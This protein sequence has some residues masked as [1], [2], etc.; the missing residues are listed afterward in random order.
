[1]GHDMG[2]ASREKWERKV[3]SAIQSAVQ[4]A[5]Q[6]KGGGSPWYETNLLWVPLTTAFAIILFVVAAM[7]KGDFRL[8]LL[9]A[10]GLLVHPFWILTSNIGIRRAYLQRAV[11]VL[12][13]LLSASGTYGFYNYLEEEPIAV[14]PTEIKLT[15]LFH[16]A[17]G[18]KGVVEFSV[19]NRGDDPYYEI[20]AK[21]LVTSD[22]L[23]SETI[24][25]D[26]PTVEERIGTGSDP[27]G[28]ALASG[29]LRGRDKD[30]HS[31]FLCVIDQLSPK[32][33]F[34]IQLTTAQTNPSDMPE[35][36]IGT[37]SIQIVKFSNSPGRRFVNFPGKERGA[38]SEH[39]IP[40]QFTST[41]MIHFC[42]DIGEPFKS[43]SPITCTPHSKYKIE[44]PSAV[45][46]KRTSKGT[47]TVSPLN[48]S[49]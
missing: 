7:M 25:L 49:L 16:P 13:L 19:Y 29:C 44:K 10:F 34:K 37:T 15:D 14:S 3:Q 20:W 41:T 48:A 4:T 24:D 43:L 5:S 46:F 1:M 21:I 47:S 2:R 6:N 28:V 32:D 23:S 27:R 39:T 33:M 30:S 18:L 11:F 9:L 12:L 22:L 26:F 17:N 8:L 36:K 45:P 35:E 38:G 42:P 31:G 40:E